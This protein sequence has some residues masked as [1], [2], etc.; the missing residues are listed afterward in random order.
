MTTSFRYWRED[1]MKVSQARAAVLLGKSLS[2]IKNYDSG[3]SRSHGTPS[4]PD[5]STRIHMKALAEHIEITPWP[6]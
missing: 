5:I 2:Q 4:V 6:E 1:V 3:I